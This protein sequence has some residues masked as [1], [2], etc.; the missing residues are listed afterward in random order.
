MPNTVEDILARRTRSLLLN[1]K[2]SEEIAPE[3]ADIM[4]KELGFNE[5]W[6]EKQLEE[7]HQLLKNYLLP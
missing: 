7:Y 6:K 1:A 4:I 5:N 2:A 3:I